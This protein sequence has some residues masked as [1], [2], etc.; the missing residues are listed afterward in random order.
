MKCMVL[1]VTLFTIIK[2]WSLYCGA[3]V[4]S[5]GETR[6][7]GMG[8]TELD[9]KRSVGQRSWKSLSAEATHGRSPELE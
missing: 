6:M 9:L 4:A 8:P 2:E 1:A 5:E 3:N 7:A